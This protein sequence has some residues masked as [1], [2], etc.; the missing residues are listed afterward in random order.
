MIDLIIRAPNQTAFE[1][2]LQA[3]GMRGPQNQV[4]QFF[5]WAPWAGTGNLAISNGA[6]PTYLTGFVALCHVGLA[7]DAISEGPAQWQR[8]SFAKGFKD[9]GT[10]MTDAELAGA[11]YLKWGSLDLFDPDDVLA[12]LSANNLPSHEWAGGNQF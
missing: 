4:V 8:S 1:A 7:G 3:Q 11:A 10:D 5:D 6:S 9:N 2:F 12:F